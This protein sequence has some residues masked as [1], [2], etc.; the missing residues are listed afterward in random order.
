MGRD[1]MIYETYMM[2]L[3]L[4]LVLVLELE[5]EVC[6]EMWRWIT[7]DTNDRYPGHTMLLLAA[8]SF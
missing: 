3:V 1:E 7:L 8:P 6:F 4:R 5:L 2:R